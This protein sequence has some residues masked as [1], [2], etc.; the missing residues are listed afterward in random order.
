[1]SILEKMT[2]LALGI[3]SVGSLTGCGDNGAT[4][5]S[6]GSTGEVGLSLQLPNGTEIQ[7]ASYSITGPMGFIRNGAIEASGSTGLTAIIGGIPAGAGYQISIIAMTSDGSTTCTGT[8]TFDINAKVTT[9][10]VVPMTCLEKPR[11]G[12]VLVNGRLNI[13][14]TIDGVSAN[15]AEVQVGGT[16]ALSAAAHDSDAGPSPLS[17]GWTSS[18]GTLSDAAAKNPTFTCT[19]P[20]TVTLRL[21]VGDGDPAA[22]CADASTVQVTCSPAARIPGSYVAG[23]FHNHTTCSDGSISMQKLVKKATDRVDT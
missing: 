12:S 17:F 14:P 9:S 19:T 23:D 21:S 16:I 10:A 5:E 13:C 4:A 15:P 8:T 7:S 1:M 11:T 22:S 18:G 3:C 20:G 2:M 6:P